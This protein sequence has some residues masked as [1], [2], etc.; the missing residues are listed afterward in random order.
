MDRKV[1]MAGARHTTS[2]SATEVECDGWV[3]MGLEKAGCDHRLWVCRLHRGEA[4]ID[5]LGRAVKTRDVDHLTTA[6]AA[7]AAVEG[8]VARLGAA[9]QPRLHP[10]CPP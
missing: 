1:L 10:E 3:W 7:G 4:E 6:D 5:K 8:L 9:S 2:C